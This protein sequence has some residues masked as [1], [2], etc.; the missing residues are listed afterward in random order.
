ML[1]TPNTTFLRAAT[2]GAQRVQARTRRRSSSKADCLPAASSVGAAGSGCD[3][4]GGGTE[5]SAGTRAWAGGG[6]GS[7]GERVRLNFEP[8]QGLGRDGDELRP[9]FLQVLQVPDR[10]VEQL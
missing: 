1:P 7:C 2:S 5:R 8:S 10:G 9:T 4:A 6:F 3:S